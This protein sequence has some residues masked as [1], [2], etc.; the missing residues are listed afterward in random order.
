MWR[1]G[2]LTCEATSNEWYQAMA[3]RVVTRLKGASPGRLMLCT[4]DAA[5]AASPA[6]TAARVPLQRRRLQQQQPPPDVTR[7]RRWRPDRQPG[8]RRACQQAWPSG[9]PAAGLAA[10]PTQS[11]EARLAPPL[12]KGGAPRSL[13]AGGRAGAAGQ[14]REAGAVPG[15]VKA[16]PKQSAQKGSSAACCSHWQVC[17]AIAAAAAARQG[18]GDQG[19]RPGW[20]MHAGCV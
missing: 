15:C 2:A 4:I 7:Q 8:C 10:P 19:T 13:P 14:G 9:M 5:A 16:N 11:T 12:W 17:T 1:G 20:R 6:R 3:G 18:D